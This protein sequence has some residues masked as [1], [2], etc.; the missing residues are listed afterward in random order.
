[1][2]TGMPSTPVT[3]VSRTTR[4]CARSSE[5]RTPGRKTPTPSSICT[6][7][8]GTPQP[9][10]PRSA[11]SPAPGQP[12]DS[13]ASPAHP[14]RAATRTTIDPTSRNRRISGRRWK[15]RATESTGLGGDRGVGDPG[16][17]GPGSA[18][19]SWT[20]GPWSLIP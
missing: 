16:T 13:L 2:R 4:H 1:V 7:P 14:A 6:S 20:G 17:R 18:I 8:A 10:R 15:G 19:R 11:S 5:T 9:P 3:V 12:S